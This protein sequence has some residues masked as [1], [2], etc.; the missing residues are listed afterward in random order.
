MPK[1]VEYPVK[2]T[3]LWRQVLAVSIQADFL[4][5]YF[6]V[7][8]LSKEESPPKEITIIICNFYGENILW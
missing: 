7:R 6:C 1:P 2:G 3:V 8:Q 4:A 5:M